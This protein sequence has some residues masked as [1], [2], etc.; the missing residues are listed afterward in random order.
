[1]SDVRSLRKDTFVYLIG[2]YTSQMIGNKLPSNRQILRVLFYNIREVK[3][4]VHESAKLTIKEVS[5][6]WDKARI[7]TRQ[8]VHCVKQLEKLYAEWRALQK[9]AK[10]PS[11]REKEQIFVEKLDD[12]FDISHAN[13]LELMKIDEDKQFLINQR[14]KGR[15]GF[16][17]GIDYQL[18]SQE[19]SAEEKSQKLSERMQRNLQEKARLVETVTCSSSSSSPA[20][21]NENEDEIIEAQEELLQ[22]QPGPSQPKKKRLY[23]TCNIITPKIA[24]AFDACKISDRYG[25]HILT[26]VAEALGHDTTSLSIS[27][28]T[29]QRSRQRIR[30]ER[31]AILKTAFGRPLGWKTFT[32][33]NWNGKCR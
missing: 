7:L 8:D 27:R 16:M 24:A 20:D 33:S 25:V 12:L 18:A 10:R 28:T 21:S 3:L 5:V 26:A 9:S 17:H 4:S 6:F 22:D 13:A 29:L 31:A 32:F 15:P 14:K 19:K 11:A 30:E 2:H 23:G 1:M